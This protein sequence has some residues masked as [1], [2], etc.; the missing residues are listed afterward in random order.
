[1]ARKPFTSLRVFNEEIG[2][3]IDRVAEGGQF[4]DLIYMDPPYATGQTFK[5]KDGVV[6][7][8]DKGSPSQVAHWICHT[9]NRLTEI[10]KEGAVI[11]IHVDFRLSHL[12]R[13]ILESG[14]SPL[15]LVNTI[16]WNYRRWP[17][18][19]KAFQ[20]MHDDLLVYSKGE[21]KTFNT[22]LGPLADS[23]IK[24]FKGK[25]QVAQYDAT[26]KRKPGKEAEDSQGTPLSDVWTDI[27]IIAPVSKERT[28]Y[29]TQKP[30]K[31]LERIV[32]AF[33][34]PGDMVLDPCA[35]SGTTAVAAYSLGRSCIAVDQSPVATAIIQERIKGCD[36]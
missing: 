14:N 35:G 21:I 11:V 26:G 1:M 12:I 18:K 25:K 33:S 32:K 16:V 9:V 28:G 17:V 22:E 36:T 6:A 15:V 19:T 24:T 23:T 13:F 20:R 34:N 3:F 4:V 5:T 27:G 31:L 29:P 8:E 30:L 2:A 7:F 10:M